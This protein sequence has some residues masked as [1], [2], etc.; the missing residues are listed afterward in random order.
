MRGVELG[1]PAMELVS[2]QSLRNACGTVETDL[3][4]DRAGT[5]EPQ[6]VKTRQRRL[7]DADGHR[8]PSRSPW[9]TTRRPRKPTNPNA[10]YTVNLTD[11]GLL[12]RWY[13]Q[14]R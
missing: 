4:P 10:A 11:P 12:S 13:A 5:F 7:T 9:P 6:I 14:A 8:T 3:A 2:E 1:T